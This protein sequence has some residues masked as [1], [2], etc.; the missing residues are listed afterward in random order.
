MVIR[1]GLRCLSN[2]PRGLKWCSQMRR[3]SMFNRRQRRDFEQKAAKV[4]QGV[5]LR[6]GHPV[7]PSASLQSSSRFKWCSRV[8]RP[9]SVCLPIGLVLL[10]RG[11]EPLRSMFNRFSSAEKKRTAKLV[12]LAV[13]IL[14]DARIVSRRRFSAPHCAASHSCS[15][16]QRCPSLN[17]QCLL[18]RVPAARVSR[19]RG[20]LTA[21]RGH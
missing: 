6:H 19:T 18:N 1:W 14:P 16:S 12:N 17:A 15:V 13:L 10:R 7:G 9:M 5:G 3:R 4:N 20:E 2:R 8:R 11:S 21:I